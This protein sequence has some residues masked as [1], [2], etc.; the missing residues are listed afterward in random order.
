MKQM[1]VFLTLLLLGGFL[2]WVIINCPDHNAIQNRTLTNPD[3]DEIDV[4]L[5]R[6]IDDSNAYNSRRGIYIIKDK[7][8]GTEYIGVSGIGISERKQ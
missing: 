8:T 6:E 2:S 5:V 7:R 3:K 1:K 4:I